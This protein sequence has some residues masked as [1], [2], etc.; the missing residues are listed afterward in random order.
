MHNPSSVET[1]PIAVGIG[2]SNTEMQTSYNTAN[3]TLLYRQYITQVYRYIISRVGN[4]ADA[5]DLTSEVFLAAYEGINRFDG[6]GSFPAWLFTIA[7]NKIVDSYRKNRPLVSLEG[8]PEQV[9]EEVDPLIRLSQEALIDRLAQILPTMTDEQRS[10]LQLRFAAELTHAQIAE[11]MGKSEGAI[12]MT[13]SRLM[14]Q[15]E[16]KLERSDE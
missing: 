7:R 12:K 4:Q 14:R 9:A 15:L 13:Y 10:I 1:I 11:V 6:Q 5:E 3:F 8:L 2:E 16:E